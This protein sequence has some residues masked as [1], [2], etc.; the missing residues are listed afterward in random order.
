MG[1]LHPSPEFITSVCFLLV[2]TA[3]FL[4]RRVV[5]GHRRGLSIH[6]TDRAVAH[7]ALLEHSTAFLNRP[8]GVVPSSILTGERYPNIHAAPYGP[9]WRAARRNVVAGVLHP[10]S[11]GLLGDIRARALSR[12]VGDLN[13]GVLPAE[14]LHFAV[15]SVLAEMCFGEDVVSELGETRLRAMHKLQRDVLRALPSLAVLVRYPRMGKLLY[16]SRWRQVLAFRRQQDE[17]FLPIV[18]Q[19]KRRSHMNKDPSSFKFKTYVESLVDLRI[20]E[21]DGACRAATD[22]ELVS[23]ISEFLGAGTEATAAALQWTMANLTKRPDLQQKLRAEMVA[24]ATACGCDVI[25]EVELSRMPYLRATVLES[26]RCHPPIPFVMR[27]MEREVAAKVLGFTVPDRGA[28]VNFLVGKI[29]RDPATWSDPTEFRPERFMSGTIDAD[30]TCTRDLTMMPFG[31]GRRA[32]PAIAPAM[33]HLQYF[34]AN[35][36][37]EFEWWEADGDDNAVDLTEFRGLFVT[38]MKRPLHA[39]LVPRHPE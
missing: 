33:L 21:D 35:L 6:V 30:L 14:C 24:V 34:V 1:M 38:I 15:Y 7:R 37:R 32:C 9:Y 20:R 4:R 16:P 26:L 28:T 31:A 13:S 18:A 23:L 3:V 11:L 10:S 5:H 17:S 8:I 25:D 29:G 2:A 19:V 12:L 39:R 27:H 36:V 22:G